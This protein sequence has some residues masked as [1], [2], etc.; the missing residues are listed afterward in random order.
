MPRLIMT[1]LKGKII[2][3][4]IILVGFATALVVYAARVPQLSQNEIIVAEK[5]S[6]G[7]FDATKI[8]VKY[9]EEFYD[10]EEYKLTLGIEDVAV[11]E[12]IIEDSD[13]AY[14]VAET[15][16]EKENVRLKI[17]EYM[18]K[19]EIEFAEPNYI[20]TAMTWS[21]GATTAVPDDFD[22]TKHWY[23]VDGN[24]PEMWKDQDCPTGGNCGASS[25]I[26]VAVIDTGLAFESYDDTGAT[27]FAEQEM[28]VSGGIDYTAVSPEF[29]TAG[30]FNL[31]ENSVEAAFGYNGKD[32]DCNG[33]IDDIHGFDVYARDSLSFDVETCDELT[34]TIPN[35]FSGINDKYL[36]K[37]G[38]PIDTHGHG[39]LVTGLIAGVV[40]DGGD[41]V[42]PAFNVTILP[43]A[44]NHHY[45]LTFDD[46]MLNTAMAEIVNL[47]IPVDIINLEIGGPAY[48]GALETRIDQLVGQEGIAII[49][50]SGN[51][52]TSGSLQ[53][54]TYPAAYDNVI[55]VGAVNH[56]DT[57]SE[58][59]NG[60]SDLD[61]VA[62][63]GET[64]ALGSAIY[65]DTLSCYPCSDTD[66]FNATA[67]TTAIGT[68]FAAPQAS[69]AAAV[70]LTNN[71]NLTPYLLKAALINTSTDIGDPGFDDDTGYGVLNFPLV[72]GFIVKHYYY[73]FYATGS[74]SQEWILIVNPDNSEVV[75]ADINI[76]SSIA[77]NVSINPE[78]NSISKYGV[79][80]GP[81][82]LVTDGTIFTTKRTLLNGSFNEFEGIAEADLA[83]AYYYPFYANGSGGS[84]EWI[85]VGNP[86]QESSVNVNIKVGTSVNE[87]FVLQPGEKITP[88]WNVWDGPVIV[89]ASGGTV[90]STKRTVLNGSFNE[91]TG[92]T[93]NHFN[94][95]HYYPFYANGSGAGDWILIGNPSSSLTANVNIKIGLPSDDDYV[96]EN[97]VLNP[98][99]ALTPSFPAWGS[100]VVITSDNNIYTTKRTLI[101]GSFNEMK[102]ITD[103]AGNNKI[104]TFFY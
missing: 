40:D 71:P 98:G 47:E 81:V 51:D 2:V 74:G 89:T 32:D 19:P 56:D 90:Y 54:V 103:T 92:I 42:S 48:S 23:Y 70:L 50:P 69:A 91:F 24:V 85:L 97:F 52:S 75:N 27:G 12:N 84:Q 93:S 46:L 1:A 17:L 95:T 104:K 86:S 20:R 30:G 35:D 76:G 33:W 60:G 28:G 22:N 65:Q 34:N 59:S 36:L 26:L 4:T 9:K 57:R 78:S 29:N 96:D 64:N 72:N 101:G 68:S 99:E 7:E 80:D 5:I 18:S 58:Y 15:E 45:S 87:N 73:P 82:D 63:V 6:A 61:L 39:T 53:P 3:A 94:T 83:T 41:M 77:D 49:A 25:N 66:S 62:Y 13:Q 37:Q 8:I 38:H 55:A 100:P 102:G 14:H 44:A 16:E 79:W 43:I 21:I 10:P 88:K 11:P 67:P 31:Y